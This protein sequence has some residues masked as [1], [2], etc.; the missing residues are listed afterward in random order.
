MQVYWEGKPID[1]VRAFCRER[2]WDV[3]VIRVLEPVYHYEPRNDVAK[4]VDRLRELR[5]EFPDLF[6]E[7]EDDFFEFLPAAEYE[8]IVERYEEAGSFEVPSPLWDNRLRSAFDGRI[9]E[10]IARFKPGEN[11]DE[12]VR[13]D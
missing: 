12:V 2:G 6:V 11:D 3:V 4:F 13:S 10:E 1:D 5:H 9:Y 7:I 8:V